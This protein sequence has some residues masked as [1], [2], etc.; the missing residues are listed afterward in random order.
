MRTLNVAFL[1]A[2]LLGGNLN[3]LTC[4]QQKQ[5]GRDQM[6]VSKATPSTLS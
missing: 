2:L 4:D 5:K 1:S 3:L 6:P